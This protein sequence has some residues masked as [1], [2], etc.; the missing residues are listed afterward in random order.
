MRPLSALV[1]VALLAA[2]RQD[3]TFIAEPNRG[4]SAPLVAI[5]PDAPTTDDPLRAVLRAPALDPDGDAV[6]YRYVW[7]RDGALAPEHTAEVVP[8]S[9]T[10]KGE[11]WAVT[12]IPS[13]GRL[14]GTAGSAETLV[15]NRPPTATIALA[16]AD[17]RT[18]DD[19][20]ATWT[21]ADGDGD[22]V[23]VTVA[24]LR[25]GV[26]MP[27]LDGATVPAAATRRGEL[28]TVLAT[29]DDG[30]QPG[31]TVQASLTVGNTPPVA[32][33]IAVSPRLVTPRDTLT[34]TVS[35]EDADDDP[36]THRFAWY[37]DGVEVG[38]DAATLDLGA[39][40]VGGE[41]V[42][43]LATPTD[44]TDGG[45][46]IAS[47]TIP[48]YAC[49]LGRER[50]CPAT[51]CLAILDSGLGD[52]DGAYWLDGDGDEGA[53]PFRAWCD[54]TGGGWTLLGKQ[55][56]APQG[57][58]VIGRHVQGAG[59]DLDPLSS[60]YASI[61]ASSVRFTASRWADHGA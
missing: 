24:W 25:E 49:L 51:S 30:D 55:R 47:A 14:D 7:Y 43:V 59:I 46:P 3:S 33:A 10:S 17:P 37:V 29:P 48:V 35:A 36:V 13:D 56:T 16:P 41:E 15:R 20:V 58:P 39:W 28:W 34:A 60:G 6:S 23:T 8:A 18:A 32:T 12:A 1:V 11:R 9:A 26:P 61:D 4:P 44:G 57:T 52:G 5:E 50:D 19:L 42:Q 21:T 27:G 45:A 38:E 54:L 53:A 2:C 31:E 22:P 40:T